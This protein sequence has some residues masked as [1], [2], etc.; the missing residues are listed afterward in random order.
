M[1][2]IA[3][4]AGSDLWPADARTRA[5]IMRWQSWQL[6]HWAKAC[7]PMLAENVVKAFFNRGPPDPAVLAQ[8]TAEFE[9]EGALLDRHLADHKYLVND[10]L[11][12]ADFSVASYLLHAERAQMPVAPLA[13]VR[14]WLGTV[15]GLPAWRNTAPQL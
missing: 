12:L 6:Q 15:A 3:E 8:A 2:Y 10:R 4:K 5:D 9:T 13:N 14:R 1:Q 7:E 11:T